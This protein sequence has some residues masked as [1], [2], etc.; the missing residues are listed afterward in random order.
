MIGRLTWVWMLSLLAV[1][2]L[3]SA[4]TMQELETRE[5]ELKAEL[6]QVQEQMT[7]LIVQE[8]ENLDAEGDLKPLDLN[9]FLV[10][11]N[12]RATR[13]QTLKT[14]AQK[15]SM[16]EKLNEMVAE[17]VEGKLVRQVFKVTNVK[18][19]PK[20][21]AW[22]SLDAKATLPFLKD[23]HAKGI[24][25]T[26]LPNNLLLDI[27]E[28]EALAINPGDALLLE[29]KLSMEKSTSSLQQS[30][31]DVVLKKTVLMRI[32]FRGWSPSIV[33]PS[34]IYVQ[35]IKGTIGSSKK[36]YRP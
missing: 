29:G 5:S 20:G 19:T 4:V 36:V 26:A 18:M 2:L 8:V 32:R 7:A 33:H 9:G 24:I 23:K 22:V 17:T 13:V 30:L 27:P 35:D 12:K 34:V 21:K 11:L 16:V 1:P 14:D 3:C 15:A 25:C 6:A 10:G 31:K 28:D